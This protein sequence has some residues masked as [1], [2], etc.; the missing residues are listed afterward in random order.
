MTRE[1]KP[2]AVRRA[3]IVSAALALAAHIGPQ[4]VTAEAI[5]LRIGLTQPAIFRHFHSKDDIWQAVIQWLEDELRQRWSQAMA[6]AEAGLRIE[7]VIA[8]HFAFV[9]RIPAMPLV[10]LSPELRRDHAT[11]GRGADRLIAAFHATVMEAVRS[12]QQAGA[13]ATQVAPADAAHLLVALVQGTALRWAIGASKFD[14]MSEG[15][16]LVRL[17]IQGMACK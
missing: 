12:G 10:L 11:I 3:E 17:T 6:E 16:N 14:L 8:A 4:K 2:A 15:T 13:I 9:A 5:A 1:R 7:A